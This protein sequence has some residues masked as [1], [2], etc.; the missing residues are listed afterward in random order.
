MFKDLAVYANP[1]MSTHEIPANSADDEAY[2]VVADG[3]TTSYSSGELAE[4]AQ[5]LWSNT[6]SASAGAEGPVFLS[7]DLETPLGFASFLACSTNFKKVFVPG[8]F[9]MSQLLKTIPMQKSSFLVCDKEFYQLE[10]PPKGD[11]V[12]M[13]SQIENVLVSGS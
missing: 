9:N 3:K 1:S 7:C 12:E 11:Y 2:C 10:A 5:D 4:K 6:L 13:C 8:T